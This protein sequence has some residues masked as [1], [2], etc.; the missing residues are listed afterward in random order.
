MYEEYFGLKE[1]PFNITPDPSFLYESQ[2]HMELLSH[3]HYGVQWR[4]GF[5][6]I[7]GEIGAGKTTICRKF[8][9]SLDPNTASALILNPDLAGTDLLATIVEDFGLEPE[10]TTKKA[11]FDCLNSFLLDVNQ[12]GG[13][14]VLIIDE[15]QNL[16]LRALE[17]IRLLS[18][19][20]TE[21]DKLVQ[22]ILV[23]QP[24][25][26]DVLKKPKLAQLRQRIS[27][28]Y[29]LK[30]LD[31]TDVEKYI[32]HRLRVAGMPAGTLVFSLH[33]VRM[34]YEYTRGIPRMI[35][36]VCDKALLAAYVR[37]TGDIC[38][39]IIAAAIREIE[40]DLPPVIAQL[41]E[42]RKAVSSLRS[43]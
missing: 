24:E 36:A 38:Q 3:L 31:F 5:I 21:K 16:S 43:S 26:R 8:L 23:G 40:G 32:Y 15:A 11:L 17:Q 37:E 30:G 41:T 1:S 19:L 39:N 18:N 2:G 7:S 13:N 42:D 27:V 9:K 25:L 12:R 10:K 35:N 20:E 28:R 22:V 4:K 6:E 33:A 14:A 29:H 34:I